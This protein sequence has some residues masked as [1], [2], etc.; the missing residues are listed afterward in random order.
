[1]TDLRGY[2]QVI[3]EWLENEVPNALARLDIGAGGL[4]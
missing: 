2:V 4:L 1:M 3:L